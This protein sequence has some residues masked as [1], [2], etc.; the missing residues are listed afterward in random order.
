MR[1]LGQPKVVASAA[2]AAALSTLLSLPRMWLWDQRKLPIWYLEATIFLGGFVLWAFVFAWHT[3]YTHRPV[4]T[5]KIK[6]TVIAVVTLLGILGAAMSRCLF[7]PYL[8]TINPEE[9]PADLAHWLAS[10]LWVLAFNQL[11]LV[12]A[13]YA[14]A[15]R[16]F[17]NEKMATGFTV[18]FF[19]AVWLLKVHSS[20]Q[21]LPLWLFLSLFVSRIVQGIFLVWFYLRGGV[22]VIW[23]LGLLVEARNLLN[24][25][26]F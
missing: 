19:V 16:L 7:D 26:H 21:A 4:F 22:L 23:W 18:T 8:R 1:R 24:F 2:I 13:P 5:L 3:E 11:F 15:I 12:F 25:Y 10:I 14:W 17:Q 9:Y 6:P 20:P